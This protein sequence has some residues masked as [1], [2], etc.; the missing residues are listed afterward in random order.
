MENKG[1]ESK[2]DVSC[3]LGSETVRVGSIFSHWR[4]GT[5]SMTFIYEDS[6]LAR[7]DA[8]ALE[9]GLTLHSGAHQTPTGRKIFGA[10]SDSSPDR[11]GRRI[12]ER[13]ESERARLAGETPRT[14]SE[15]ALMLAI[16]DD[17][18]QGAL[19]FSQN[20]GKFLESE[21]DGI[22]AKIALPHLIEL[23]RKI[24]SDE[25]GLTEMQN[26]FLAGGS[27]GGA[28]PKAH[29]L[30]DDGSLAIAKF[31]RPEAD[32]WDVI[33]WEKTVLDLASLAK[34]KVP[35][36]DLVNVGA[37]KVLIVK[38]FDRIREKR[39]GYVSAM[40]MLEKD[41]MEPGSYLDI[42]DKIE[43]TSLNAAAELIELWRR[44]I[45]T[46][47]VTNKDDHLKNH[48]FLKTKGDS[49]QLSPAFDLNPD[50][51]PGRLLV[52]AIDD[53]NNEASL[54]LCFAVLEYFRLSREKALEILSEVVSAIAAWESIA[55]RHGL[56]TADL[57]FMEPAFSHAESKRAAGMLAN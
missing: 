21:T 40:T 18:R 32:E 6:Y 39:L 53:K 19:R 30:Y 51:K 12:I 54:E 37:E 7:D 50:P 44:M 14:M 31:S 47:L 20:S 49:W 27:L 45:F 26:L 52:T 46:V 11:W 5:E 29:I 34:I 56:K 24:D 22:P 16:R 8:Y 48:G 10:F 9:P 15:A 25:A 35:N 36:S 33:T 17:L 38:R 2:I 43:T 41:E 42:A 57:K 1:Q 23:A 3:E 55:R 13:R 28:R 4:K